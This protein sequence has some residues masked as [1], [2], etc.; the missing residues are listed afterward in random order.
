MEP[1]DW[2]LLTSE[3]VQSAVEV[4]RIIGWYR[5]RWLVEEWH[6]VLKEG[7]KLESSQLDDAVDIQRLAAIQSIVSVRMIQLRD[8]AGFGD[9]REDQPS[10]QDESENPQV[11]QDTVPWT[12]IRVVAALTKIEPTHLTS[13][14][15][16]L[17]I[18]KQGGFIGRKRD[19]RPGW[20]AI[21]RGWYEISIMVR[22]AE[23]FDTGGQKC[24]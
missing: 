8:L 4:R 16:W 10:R 1:I 24:G 22:G 19:G 14:Q 23:L 7:C 11:L 21:W 20:K 5:C 6:R 15:F 17:G 13:R 18:A 2:M 3:P 9:D 12:W